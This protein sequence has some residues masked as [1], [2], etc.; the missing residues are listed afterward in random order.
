RPRPRWRRRSGCAGRWG[1]GRWSPWL[2]L[3]V[4]VEGT[5]EGVDGRG[6]RGRRAHRAGERLQ[7][8]QAVAGDVGH[9]ALVG[10]DDALLGELLQGG[11]RDTT[12][13]L[14]EDPLRP[15]EELHPVDDLVVG[16]G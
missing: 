14:G 9:D 1:C 15:G 7:R 10:A 6:D 11:D 2:G 4:D 16:D 8:L 5:G 12:G 3:L 13:R